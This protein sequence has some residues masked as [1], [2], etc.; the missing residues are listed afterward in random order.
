MRY[1]PVPCDTGEKLKAGVTIVVPA[2]AITPPTAR[3]NSVH[4]AVRAKPPGGAWSTAQA[5]MPLKKR[6]SVNTQNEGRADI[7][8]I[9][10]TRIFLAANTL[11]VIYGSASTSARAKMPPQVSLESGEVQAG[12]NALR[13]KPIKV[14]VKGGAT[15]TAESR[16]AVLRKKKKRTTVSVF[17]GK[18]KVESAG[19]A[20][21]VPKNFGSSFAENRAPKKPRPLPPPPPWK[22]PTSEG[23][24]LAPGGEGVIQGTW[25]SVTKAIGYRLEV[26]T[27]AGFQRLVVRQEIPGKVQNFRAEKMPPGRYWMR[28]RAIDNDDFLGIASTSKNVALVGASL[29]D[30]LGSVT[31][32]RVEVSPYGVLSMQGASGVQLSLDDGPFGPVPKAV[33]LQKRA[34]KTLTFQAEDGGL[35]RTFKIAYRRVLATIHPAPPAGGKSQVRVDIEGLDGVD[36][37]ILAPVLKYRTAAGASGQTPLAA[38]GAGA[39][40]ASLDFGADDPGVVRFDVIDKRGRMLGSAR[41]D[42]GPDGLAPGAE[43]LPNRPRQVGLDA[44]LLAPS[45]IAGTYWFSARARDAASA[46]GVAGLTGDD[47]VGQ[48][49]AMVSGTA[50]DFGFDARVASNGTSSAPTDTGA[51][52][53][54]RWAAYEQGEGLVLGPAV[55]AGLPTSQGSPPARVEPALAIGGLVG[56]FG[57]LANVG[58]RIAL[59]DDQNRQPVPDVDAFTAL[60]VTYDFQPWLRAY[61]LLDGHLLLGDDTL[62]RGSATLGAEVGKTLFGSLGLRASPWEDF[63]GSFGGQLSLG[64]RSQ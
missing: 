20:V 17:D 3:L 7:R 1:E 37:A 45:P 62:G 23:F 58:S 41:A 15:V 43:T 10:R 9:D 42:M 19:K 57:W 12:L 13:G 25:G 35:K 51:W 53:G 47:T 27:D 56:E 16:D 39:F 40:M 29:P 6:S 32:D 2:R 64:V 44:P 61:A 36:S 33:D 11:V 48:F 63:G 50:G 46:Y 49:G 5:G 14:A 28:V 8:F 18:A 22:K 55:R 30:T 38:S 4:P 52:L 24:L 21:A 34:P 59:E 60:G 26:A 31:S 54:A